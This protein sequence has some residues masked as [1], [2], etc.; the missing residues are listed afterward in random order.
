[1]IFS[2]LRSMVAEM[3]KLSGFTNILRTA[4]DTASAVEDLA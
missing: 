1:M 3:F 2:D 4:P